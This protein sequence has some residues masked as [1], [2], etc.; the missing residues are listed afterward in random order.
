MSTTIHAPLLRLYAKRRTSAAHP[1]LFDEPSENLPISK[2]DINRVEEIKLKALADEYR[3]QR[4]V[5][6]TAIQVYA[7]MQPNWRGGRAQLKA[8]LV[9]LIDGYIQSDRIVIR[10]TTFNANPLRRRLTITLNLTRV[11]HHVWQAIR[12]QNT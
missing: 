8:Q 6:E 5:F 9:R 10:P 1:S 7:P 2:A 3:M 11:V 4:I 12:Y